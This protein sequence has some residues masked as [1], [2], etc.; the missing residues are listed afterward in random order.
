MTYQYPL[1]GGKLALQMF[2]P[3]SPLDWI[4]QASMIVALAQPCMLTQVIHHPRAKQLSR[5]EML[6]SAKQRDPSHT[7]RVHPRPVPRE[8]RSQA[9]TTNTVQNFLGTTA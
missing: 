4:Q 7:H 3:G 6:E 5:R 8:A 9:G 1:D 2:A